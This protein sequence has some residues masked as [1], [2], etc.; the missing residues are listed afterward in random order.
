MNEE[1]LS[2]LTGIQ[3]CKEMIPSTIINNLQA[4]VVWW[5]NWLVGLS[6]R[7]ATLSNACGKRNVQVQ[8]FRP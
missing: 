7:V 6:I 3:L 4:S 5:P 1:H 2:L 8:F